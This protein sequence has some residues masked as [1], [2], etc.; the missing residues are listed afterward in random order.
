MYSR[1]MN[2]V[3][4]EELLEELM[5]APDHAGH[6]VTV[7]NVLDHKTFE[8]CRIKGSINVEL[9]KLN[10]YVADWDR[11]RNIVVYCASYDCPLSEQ[12]YETLNNMGFRNVRAY[13]GGMQEWREMGYPNEG[14]CQMDY[15]TEHSPNA[16][17][18]KI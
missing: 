9:D 4:A 17:P 1:D 12:A 15:L 18:K 14:V 16:A 13:E 8:D 2:I 5:E 3:T 7:I 6:D 11:D 10:N